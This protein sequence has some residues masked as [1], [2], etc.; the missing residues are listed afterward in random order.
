MNKNG[1][2]ILD[3]G[4]FFFIEVVQPSFFPVLIYASGYDSGQMFYMEV[5]MPSTRP[6]VCY[7]VS[8]E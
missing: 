4:N 3:H 7:L 2:G 6:H 1:V 8:V 5:D